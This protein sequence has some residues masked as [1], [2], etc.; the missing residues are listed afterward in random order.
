MAQGNSSTSLDIYEGSGSSSSSSSTSS[1]SGISASSAA[2]VA[3]Q[4]YRCAGLTWAELNP[5]VL[6]GTDLLYRPAYKGSGTQ[7]A[8]TPYNSARS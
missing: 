8:Y 3:R 2:N 4:K 7:V 6:G 1:S 5:V